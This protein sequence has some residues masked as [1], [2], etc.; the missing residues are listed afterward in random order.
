MAQHSRLA[1]ALV[2]LV[3][4]LIPLYGVL[5]WQWDTF[6]LLMLY[7]TETVIIAFWSLMRLSK[8]PEDRL[9]TMTVNGREQPATR[10]GLLW[11]FATHAGAF[12][13]A[14]LLFLWALFASG[15][16][17]NVH[18]AGGILHELFVANGIWLALIFMFVAGWIGFRS[19]TDDSLLTASPATASPAQTSTVQSSPVDRSAKKAGADAVGAIVSTLYV[20]ILIMQFAIIAGAM[21]AQSSGSLAPLLIVIGFKTLFDL[22][23]AW[24]TSDGKDMTSQSATRPSKLRFSNKTL[25]FER[26]CRGSNQTGRRCPQGNRRPVDLRLRCSALSVSFASAASAT[27]EADWRGCDAPP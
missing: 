17:K 22:G 23:S 12:I 5:Y 9:G 1:S 11:F 10:K 14:H 16:L 3:A 27:A 26:R 13:L 20:R 21:F 4:N 25:D 7:W 24:R 19:K 2:G 18:G 15:W 6:Q 8:L